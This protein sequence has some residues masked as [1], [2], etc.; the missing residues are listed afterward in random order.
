MQCLLPSVAPDAKGRRQL[1]YNC[2]NSIHDVEDWLT[3][4]FI[5]SDD[6]T[7]RPAMHEICRENLAEWIA[8]AFFAAPLE[9]V[10]EDRDNADELYWMVDSFQSR[11]HVDIKPGY[12]DEIVALRLTLDPVQAYHR[13]LAFYVMISMMTTCI[14]RFFFQMGFGFARYGPE[15]PSSLSLWWLS[16]DDGAA[17]L[18][19]TESLCYWF[20][21]GDRT[22]KP[23][24]FVHGIGPGF[25]P[26]LFFLYN[27]L[28]LTPAPVFCVELPHVAMRG[29]EH[30]PTMQDTVRDLDRMLHSHGF[31]DAVFVAHSLGTG[32]ISWAVQHLPK[33]DV[34][35]T[36]MP[37]KTKI[38]LSEHD[39]IVNSE[40][41]HDYLC[42]HGIDS[43]VM[44]GL[45]HGYFLAKYEWQKEILDTIIEYTCSN[46][47]DL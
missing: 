40:R 43:T 4:W 10:L 7:R 41:V 29:I 31:S 12:D 2:I 28:R 39:N 5:K 19:T 11:F 16:G 15:I 6:A 23:V 24:V 21:D 14:S 13:P 3:G 9:D 36:M 17:S 35:T 45:D 25:M 8:W 26:Y 42:A 47:D 44:S 22:K 30:S 33:S 27:L 1:F 32:I 20:R 46:D 34:P 37:K 18:S 38:F